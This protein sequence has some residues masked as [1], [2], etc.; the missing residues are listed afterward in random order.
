M[1]D[2]IRNE[3]GIVVVG[4]VSQSRLEVSSAHAGPDATETEKIQRLEQLLESFLNGLGQLPSGRLEA[5]SAA[6]GLHDEVTAE[7]REESRVRS[8][9]ARFQDAARNA[10]PLAGI[11]KDI[12]DLVITILGG[13][14]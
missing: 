1:P 5:A 3:Q 14:H 7:P 10:A 11:A 13:V 6:T 2:H 4:N 12:A 8:A 9:L